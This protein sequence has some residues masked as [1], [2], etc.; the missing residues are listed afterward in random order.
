MASILVILLTCTNIGYYLSS[1]YYICGI[2]VIYYHP[3]QALVDRYIIADIIGW[4]KDTKIK[5]HYLLCYLVIYHDKIKIEILQNFL[6]NTAFMIEEKLYLSNSCADVNMLFW[7]HV[8]ICVG[9]CRMPMPF[10]MA[11]FTVLFQKLHKIKP[12]HKFKI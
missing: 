9:K 4:K 1:W 7:K 12:R 2:I 6:N 11:V 5:C 3:A 8:G 10:L